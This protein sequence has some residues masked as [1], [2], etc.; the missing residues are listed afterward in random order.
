MTVYAIFLCITALNRCQMASP[1][2]MGLHGQL[3]PATAYRSLDDCRR[4]L[5][6]NPPN[7]GL[8]YKCLGKHVDTWG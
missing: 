3:I 4:G 5:P 6:R 1:P 7:G 8:Y 2:R